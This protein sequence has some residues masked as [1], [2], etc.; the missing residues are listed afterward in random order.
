MQ[1]HYLRLLK[2]WN[3]L[4]L[5]PTF[6]INGWSIRKG[7]PFIFLVQVNINFIEFRVGE[8]I[9][10]KDFK[11]LYGKINQIFVL[12]MICIGQWINNIDR[13]YALMGLLSLLNSYEQW[14][15]FKINITFPINSFLRSSY[16]CVFA[17]SI[18]KNKYK[19]HFSQ[20]MKFFLLTIS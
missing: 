16:L 14:N 1:G 12:C 13:T 17:V 18:T 2:W 3:I 10:K 7:A 5:S 9:F 11:Y 15:R 8:R 19:S 6:H 4:F 20:I